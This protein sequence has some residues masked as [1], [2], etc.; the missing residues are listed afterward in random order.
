M[1]PLS[2]GVVGASWALTRA[3]G[4]RL[5]M[6]GV[7][8]GL[9]ALTPDLDL[10]IR[11]A[12]DPLLTLEYHRT[13]T[14]SLA[15][16]FVAALLA[17]L[18]LYPWARRQ[19][20]FG[21]TY[22]LCELG[23]LSHCL[24]DACTAFGTELLW[25]FSGVRVALSIISVFDPLFTLPIIVL[26]A[27]AAR[28]RRASYAYAAIGWAGVYLALGAVQHARAVDAGARLA[29]TRG[30]EPARLVA[31]PTL[32]NVLLW[33]TLYEYAGRYYVDGVRAGLRTT[34]Y[35]GTS[36]AQLDEARPLPGLD[37]ASVQARDIRRFRTIAADLV[38]LDSAK[39]NR[40]VDLRYSMVPNE[41]G[42]FWAIV[43]DPT[44]GPTE[45]VALV[46]T[47]EDTPA[48]A[49]ELLRLLFEPPP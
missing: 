20:G 30:H 39:P 49:L 45:H 16:S 25:P 28:R 43:V 12:G 18:V 40:I 17:A 6:S 14:H 38:A 47:R 27:L 5:L 48:E 24:L 9:A 36:V 41:I 35:P 1:D 3:P 29:A 13:F 19:L 26:V 8:A 33:K 22:V 10:L 7:V 37:P 34:P 11:S 46:A 21:A 42:G 2:H 31:E 44:A 4:S 15:F 32:G 23:V